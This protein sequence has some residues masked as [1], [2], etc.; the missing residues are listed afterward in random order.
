VS[1]QL[2]VGLDF[3]GTK[4]AVV[5]ADQDGTRVA[6]CVLPTEA[7][8]G[9][10]QA[11]HRALAAARGLLTERGA[12][13]AAVGVATMGITRDDHVELAPNVPGWDR[14]AIPTMLRNEFGAAPVAIA[15]DVKAAAVAELTWGELRGVSTGMYVNLGTGFAA[16]L[17]V[18]GA[19]LEGAHGAAGE[20]GYW[21]RNRADESRD[22]GVRGPLEEYVSGAGVAARARAE[23]GID[24]GVTA[25]VRSDDP[26]AAAFLADLYDEIA[27]QI[28]N[29]A[30]AVDPEV[31]VL[32]GGF[33]RSSDGLLDAVAH[34]IDAQLPYLP[35]LRVARFGGDAATAGAIALALQASGTMTPG[36]GASR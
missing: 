35:Q 23:L 10:E 30:I 26:R 24:G 4:V 28:A 34:R 22:R 11:V 8:Q 13:V 27:L 15:N 9:A 33:A 3:G 5:L 21:A 12:E 19:V 29:L 7:E 31:V 36:A 17:I 20:I 14:L 6:S 32:G 16:A 18:R 25:L 1:D 2:L